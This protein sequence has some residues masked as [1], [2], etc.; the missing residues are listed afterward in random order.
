MDIIVTVKAIVK[1]QIAVQSPQSSGSIPINSYSITIT[2]ITS[3]SGGNP[4]MRLLLLKWPGL[5]T[6]HYALLVVDSPCQ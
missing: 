3:T 5:F 4:I 1:G 6:V 2:S